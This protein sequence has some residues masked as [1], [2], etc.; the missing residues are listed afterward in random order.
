MSIIFPTVKMTSI[1]GYQRHWLIMAL[2]LGTSSLPIVTSWSAIIGL[3]VMAF[4]DAEKSVYPY[5]N[6]KGPLP[7]LRSRTALVIFMRNEDPSLIFDRVLEMHKSL[8]QIGRFQHFRFVLLSDTTLSEVMCMEDEGQYR[9]RHLSITPLPPPHGE[10]PSNRSPPGCVHWHASIN[11]LGLSWW[12]NDSALFW[13]HNAII[14]TRAFREHCKLPV[15]SVKP[16]HHEPRYRGN[17]VH[18]PRWLR[19]P[20]TADYNREATCNILFLL[21]EPGL[22]LINRCQVYRILAKSLSPMAW[23]IMTLAFNIRSRVENPGA[24]GVGVSVL[25]QWF[26]FRLLPEIAAFLTVVTNPSEIKR[27]GGMFRFV[28]SIALEYVITSIMSTA[29]TVRMTLFFCGLLR[30]TS[31]KWDAQNRDRLG[32]SWRHTFRVFWVENVIG[33]GII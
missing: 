14:R 2:F 16:P 18:A 6:A 31:I 29:A 30:G 15:L 25:S 23:F 32:L 22:S 5:F 28:A 24:S 17:H 33:L 8:F 27:Y 1:P 21:R 9:H 20:A 13:G 19:V 4:G 7:E 26:I 3:L 12:A 11:Y 10:V